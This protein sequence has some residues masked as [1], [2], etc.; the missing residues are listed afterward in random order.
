M[1]RLPITHPA[2]LA[3]LAGAGHGSQVLIADGNYPISTAIAPRAIRVD[4]GIAPGLPD[5]TQLLELIAT[6]LPVEAATVM[7]PDDDRSVDAHDDFARI[8]GAAPD[9][10]GRF[11]FY[12]A[13]RSDRLAVAIGSADV[14]HF[15]NILIT[16]GVR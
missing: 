12:D 11:D 13:C 2:L 1:L 15:A 8:L 7:S 14:R 16:V 3:A 10:V 6:I 5:V 4:L 9:R